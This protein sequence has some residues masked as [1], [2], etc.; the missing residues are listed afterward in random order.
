MES[1]HYLLMASA[2]F[3]TMSETAE[4]CLRDQGLTF[5]QNRTKD[6]TEYEIENPAY[7]R[8]VIQKRKDADVGN[9]L[10]PSIKAAK[11][12]FLDV[13]FS[14]DQDDSRNQEATRLAKQF[15]KSLLSSLP[16]APWEGLKFRESMKAKKKWKD[17]IG[18][19]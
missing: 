6:L 16:Q 5:I 9:F 3:S 2:D 12:S 11:G 19:D 15:L 1:N 7:F 10:M 4:S 8:I 17:L 13:W 18:S 14:P